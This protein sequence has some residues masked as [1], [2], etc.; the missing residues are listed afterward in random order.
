M[1][2]E[3][4]KEKDGRFLVISTVLLL[5]ATEFLIPRR[6]LVGFFSSF[7]P[8][9]RQMEMER[10]RP[11]GQQQRERE[12][13]QELQLLRKK[14]AELALQT[15]KLEEKVRSL[16]KVPEKNL[17]LFIILL[18]TRRSWHPLDRLSLPSHVRFPPEDTKQTAR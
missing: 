2:K 17:F 10:E 1:G 12:R 11:A 8:Q 3:E 7:R 18:S 15:K 16:E 13:Q 5:L 4:R 9:K 6:L 14:N